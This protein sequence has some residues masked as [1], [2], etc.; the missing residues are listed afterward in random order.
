MACRRLGVKRFGEAYEKRK[1]LSPLAAFWYTEIGVGSGRFGEERQA[2]AMRYTLQTLRRHS[3]ITAAFWYDYRDDEGTDPNRER[4]GV[5]GNSGDLRT[6]CAG[7]DGEKPNQPFAKRASW[8]VFAEITGA[9]GRTSFDDVPSCHWAHDE[10]ESLYARGITTGTGPSRFDDRSPL[11]VKELAA[12]QKRAAG[13]LGAQ[14]DGDSAPAK[15]VDVA[16]AFYTGD[17]KA[18]YR[19]YFTDVPFTPDN[20]NHW[21]EIESLKEKKVTTGIPVDGHLEF[22]PQDTLTRATAAVFISRAFNLH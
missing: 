17:P 13:D 22:Q 9:R 14:V 3:E 2:Q 5:R 21:R 20:S 7:T 4:N 10:I 6:V 19:G 1:K 12:L 18:G 8:D 15:R 16:V 11:K